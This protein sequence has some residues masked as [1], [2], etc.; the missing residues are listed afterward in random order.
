MSKENPNELKILNKNERLHYRLIINQLK[1][2]LAEKQNTIDEINKE[3]V[4]AIHDWK[5]LCA[6]RD[7]EIEELNQNNKTFMQLV[8]ETKSKNIDDFAFLVRVMNGSYIQKLR[9]ANRRVQELEQ[10][11]TKQELTFMHSK[12]DYFQR[13][14]LLEEENIK[15]QFSQTQLAIRELEK[16][17]ASADKWFESWENSKYEGCIYDKLDVSNAY[18][19]ISCEIEEQIKKLKGE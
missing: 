6:E 16:V 8:E 11:Q 9:K 17:K 3:F 18:L 2:Q 4:Q 1:Q 5:A 19:Q 13:C 7:K 14:N 15:L 12:E 10:L